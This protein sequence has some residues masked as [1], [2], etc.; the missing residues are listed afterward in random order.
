MIPIAC[1][2][3]SAN[4]AKTEEAI[5]MGSSAIIDEENTQDTIFEE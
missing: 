1:S 4:F 3:Q 5:G 2:I